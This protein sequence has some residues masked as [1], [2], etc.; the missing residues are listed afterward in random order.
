MVLHALI[1]VYVFIVHRFS[2]QTRHTPIHIK[3]AM[4]VAVVLQ[5]IKFYRFNN[6]IRRWVAA[7]Q[8]LR[9]AKCLVTSRK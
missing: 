6:F 5:C 7:A 8:K 3:T 9:H 2:N 4:L 1:Y